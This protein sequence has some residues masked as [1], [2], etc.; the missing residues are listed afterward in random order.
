MRHVAC[1][2]WAA[3]QLDKAPHGTIL[4]AGAGEGYG[5]SEVTRISGRN[6]VAIELDEA[7]TIHAHHTY[8]TVPSVRA[9]LISL[10]CADKSFAGCVSLQ[11]IEHL[12][13]PI[14][15]LRELARCTRGPIIIS[16]PNRP[17]HSPHLNKGQK[18]DNL[19]HVQEFDADELRDLLELADPN[20]QPQLFG[21]GHGTK[22]SEW[23]HT[24]GGL[25][26][27]LLNHDSSRLA[28]RFAESITD[29]DFIIFSVDDL[30]PHHSSSRV[31]SAF[32]LIALW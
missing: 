5:T 28:Q 9:N 6:V 20:R 24:N 27:A 32:D 3:S 26:P 7:T 29:T 30:S 14:T 21:L 11:V 8:P 15:Y 2:R 17:V 12:W 19:F 13:D 25:V 4:D 31:P 23:E 1:Y 10:P 16:T 18:P 22:I